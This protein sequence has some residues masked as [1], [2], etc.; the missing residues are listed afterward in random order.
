M[1]G[2]LLA[3]EQAS[4]IYGRIHDLAVA[5]GGEG[6]GPIPALVFRTSIH[7]GPEAVHQ[8]T[9]PGPAH[10]P[11]GTFGSTKLDSLLVG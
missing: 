8:S 3:F 11:L 10:S 5:P 7:L 9:Y 6:S 1:R 2:K 4:V